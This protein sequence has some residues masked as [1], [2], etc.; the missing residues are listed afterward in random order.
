M[1]KVFLLLTMILFIP[2]LS[3]S[4]N[5]KK[6]ESKSTLTFVHFRD[7]RDLNPHLY[8]GEIY[9]QNLLYEGLIKISEDGSLKPW[10]AKSWKISKDNLTYTFQLREDVFFSDGEKF[11]AKAA[12]AN[13]NAILS[14]YKRH[15]WLESMKLLEEVRLSGKKP[16]EATGK[17][18]LTI[19]L[20]KPYYPLLVEL[21]MTRPFRFISPKAFI[22]G[23]TK[24][25]VSALSGTAGYVLAE[26]HIDQY[27]VFKINPNYWGKKPNIENVIVKVIPNNQT[28]ILA[29]RSGE[30]DLIYGA[31]MIDGES[32]E[33]FKNMPEFKVSL[34]N[35]VSSRMLMLNT[36]NGALKEL[37]V[38][39]AL[40]HAVNKEAISK[41]LF[42]GIEV[43]ADTLFAKNVPYANIDLKP[44]EYD[45]NKAKKILEDAGW[46]KTSNSKYRKKDGKELVITFN[47]DT[48]KVTD[49]RIA[50]Y[51]QQELSKIGV[52][53][54]ILGEEKQAFQDRQK[55]GKFQIMTGYTWGT[56]YDPQSFVGSMR[57]SVHGDYMAQL[58]L[59]EKPKIDA[60]ILKI[61][62]TSDE[63]KRQAYYEYIFRTLHEKAVYIPLTYSKNMTIYNKRIENVRFNNSK[64]EVPIEK[65][66][67]K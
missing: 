37:E 1:K 50:Q 12:E 51:L 32:I 49:K 60:T 67:I 44:Y 46:K 40:N 15:S 36:A 20:S 57:A 53:L 48:N 64:Y 63:K 41:G 52:K 38:R 16:I 29:L 25:G 24:N 34:S 66:K 17:Y 21:G 65:I 59:A 10:L 31:N 11:D 13:L 39:K 14:N 42:N 6:Y 43:P 3:F 27:A 54:K 28:R 33:M 45:V 62:K 30:I 61:F 22:D 2:T 9:A 7:I 47:Y 23:E 58:G 18:E 26:N 19:R 35:P 55:S 56:P 5:S 8:G 4:D